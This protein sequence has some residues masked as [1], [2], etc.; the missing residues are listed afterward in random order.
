MQ[1]GTTT[2]KKT[3]KMVMHLVSERERGRRVD[4]CM[5]CLLSPFSLYCECEKGEEE[6]DEEEKEEERGL[7]PTLRGSLCLS[8]F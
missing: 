1:E 8:P 5:S 3:M 4:G 6:E 2:K 7:Q